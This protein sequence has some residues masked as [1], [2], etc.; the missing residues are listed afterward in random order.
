LVHENLDAKNSI[1][2][3]TTKSIFGIFTLNLKMTKLNNPT[4]MTESINQS[5]NYYFKVRVL[6][7]LNKNV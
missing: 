1:N 3:L 4:K 6:S 7:P 5:K 2:V